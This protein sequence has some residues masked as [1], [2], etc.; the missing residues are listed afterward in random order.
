SSPSRLARS[1]SEAKTCSSRASTSRFRLPSSATNGLIGSAL[2]FELLVWLTRDFPPAL[3]D[4][5]AALPR[6]CAFARRALG[7]GSDL[8]LPV[9]FDFAREAGPRSV[10]EPERPLEV[11]V[12]PAIFVSGA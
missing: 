11:L 9:V 7:D 5:G 2:G 3:R 12:F 10:R 8:A 1:S 6:V 4:L